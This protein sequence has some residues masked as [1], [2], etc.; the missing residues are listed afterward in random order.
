MN[1]KKIITATLVAFIVVFLFDYL[2]FGVIF[3]DMW[4]SFMTEFMKS[5]PE[6]PNIAIHALGDLSL[7]AL[8]AWIYPAGYKGGSA[9]SEG[10]QFG[11]MMGLIMQLPGSI[12]MYD[13]MASTEL[14]CL[15]VL[16]GILAGIIGGICVAMMYGKISAPSAG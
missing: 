15:S 16:H 4:A 12:H 2:W 6:R 7:A 13:G 14:V 5:M 3:K 8:L 1:A 10:I 9:L 11:F